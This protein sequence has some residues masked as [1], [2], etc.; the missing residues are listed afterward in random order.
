MGNNA[1]IH[2]NMRFPR[3]HHP[4]DTPV[5]LI[6]QISMQTVYGNGIP[7]PPNSPATLDIDCDEIRRVIQEFL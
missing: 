3:H 1:I 4:I 5:N 6:Y 2:T 7:I